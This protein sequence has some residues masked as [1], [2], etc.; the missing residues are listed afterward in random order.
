M[1]EQGKFEGKW[2]CYFFPFLA[3]IP[4]PCVGKG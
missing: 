2:K 3:F 4:Y 1:K